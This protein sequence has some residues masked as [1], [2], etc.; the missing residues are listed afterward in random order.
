MIMDK[1]EKF[2]IRAKKSYGETS[3]VSCRMP[4]EV[5]KQLDRVSGT[6]R[7]HTQWADPKVRG[8]RARQAGNRGRALNYLNNNTGADCYGRAGVSVLRWL[9]F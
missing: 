9:F 8:I 3:V 5:L 1:E 6:H 4:N 7:T 2:I